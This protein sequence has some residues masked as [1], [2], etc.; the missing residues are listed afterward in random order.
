MTNGAGECLTQEAGRGIEGYR[1]SEDGAWIAFDRDRRGDESWQ[2]CAVELA[3][4]RIRELTPDVSH[5]SA[6]FY[7]SR[8]SRPGVIAAGLNERDA[9]W[10]DV[11]EIDLCTG[12]RR[13]V[14]QND[15]RLFSFV[16]D[17]ALR[18][19]MAV[20]A[21]EAGRTIVGIEAGGTVTPWRSVE[22]QDAA[23]SQVVSV[24]G[25]GGRV[26]WVSSE[27]DDVATMRE[28]S[29]AGEGTAAGVGSRMAD[30]ADWL[31]H[32]QT[33]EPLAVFTEG[34]LPRWTGIANAAAAIAWLT[35]TLGHALD[36]LST[37]S[38]ATRW[39]VARRQPDAPP[40]YFLVEPFA[41]RV[42][43]GPTLAQPA[44][45][46][47]PLAPMAPRSAAAR[48]GALLTTYATWPSSSRP[49]SGWPLLL[50]VHGGPGLRDSFQFD[51][52]HQWLASRGIAV[53]SVN[54]RGSAGLGKAFGGAA[55]LGEREWSAKRHTDL[56]DAVLPHVAAGRADPARLAIAGGA[57][58]GYAALVGL[59][60]TPAVF[61]CGVCICG[62][63]APPREEGPSA[64]SA[65]SSE[66]RA[67]PSSLPPPPSAGRITRPLLLAHGARDARVARS[68]A[69]QVV[70]AAE[71]NGAPVTYV[72]YGDE[73]HGL[74]RTPNRLSFY[75]MM[76]AFLSTH[77]GSRAEPF[78]DVF[79]GACIDELRGASHLPGLADAS[80]RARDPASF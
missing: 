11:W 51:A 63:A 48:D 25:A 65:S 37:T 53:L 52:R 72:V 1:W 16:F 43:A 66:R 74:S 8:A 35:A 69:E 50:W 3:T 44:L 34:L 67:T 40:A 49:A 9:R 42:V 30:V 28:S 73:G 59:S 45:A 20:R 21:E 6:R 14:L 31:L 22:P 7:A 32:P 61:A 68:E 56:L 75:A 60:S 70:A 27:G 18:P 17:E 54:Y 39:L 80:A 15:E 62:P 41:E 57:F 79:T 78:G 5:L 26:W 19:A 24:D 64:S 76:E 29:A 47:Y 13:L 71:Q 4:G 36:L 23:R 58:G 77:L 46:H 55:P 10:H 38:D 12:A 33:G 2:L